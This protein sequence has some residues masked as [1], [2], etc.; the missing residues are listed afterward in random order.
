VIW[1]D[2]VQGLILWVS[3]AICLGFLLFT[4]P[5]GPAAVF[6]E[7]AAQHKFSLGSGVISIL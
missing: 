1:T 2:F 6:R 7:A 4:S 3:I 5:G